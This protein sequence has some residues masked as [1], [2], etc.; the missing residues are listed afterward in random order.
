MPLDLRIETP[1]SLTGMIMDRLERAI[2]DGEFALGEMISEETLA[3]SFGVSRTPVRDALAALASTGLVVILNKKGSFVFQP[4]P[5]DAAQLCEYRIILETQAIRL[6]Y[7]RAPHAT[8]LSMREAIAAM[9][10]ASTDDAVAYGRADGQFHGCFFVHCGNAYLTD[11]Y[12]LAS[13]KVAALRTHLTARSR[14]RRITSYDEHRAMADHF[15]A[16]D[17][18]GLEAVLRE[19]IDRTRK[20]Y[21]A[22]LSEPPAPARRMADLKGAVA[23]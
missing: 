17:L 7:G 1:R 20:V 4:T 23:E 9:D 5:E 18:G 8:L 13:G 14:E 19:H 15:E 22:A 21:L 3:K 16:G 11:A 2:V 6:S 10:R 12:R